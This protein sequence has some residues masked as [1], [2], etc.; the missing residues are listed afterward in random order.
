MK[1]YLYNTDSPDPAIATGLLNW[2]LNPQESEYDPTYEWNGRGADVPTLGGHVYHDYGLVESDRKI[3]ITGSYLDATTMA[4][5][6]AKYAATNTEYYFSARKV[7]AVAD[8]IW[9][10][11]FRRQPRGFTCELDAPVF[12][13]GRALSQ[14]VPTG[15]ERYKYEMVLLVVS[16]L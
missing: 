10:V 9:K 8:T 11:R 14:P 2:E 5:L 4:A 3:R 6:E 12:M 15:Y 7:D 16:K 1:F 13:I